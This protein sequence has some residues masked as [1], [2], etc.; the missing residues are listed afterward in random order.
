MRWANAAGY[1]CDQFAVSLRLFSQKV[2]FV[3]LVADESLSAWLDTED[4]NKLTKDS[5]SFG[6]RACP[7][8]I[9]QN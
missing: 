3:L 9:C 2:N 7:S 1:F 5:S 4:G 6:P 8:M